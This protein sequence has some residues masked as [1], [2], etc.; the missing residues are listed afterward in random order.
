MVP[1]KRVQ[2]RLARLIERRRRAAQ[3]QPEAGDTLVEILISLAVIGITVT[4]ILGAFVTTISAST[5]QRN[6]ASADAFLRGF[7]N[8]AIYDI[9]LSSTP[10]FVACASSLPATYSQITPVAPSSTFSASIKTISAPP[11]G[12]SSSSPSTQ[13]LMAQVT[14]TNGVSDSTTF[15]V[16]PPSGTV[17]A[18]ATSVTS[19]S[20]STGP[21]A[22]GTSVVISGSGFTGVTSVKFG[23][24]AAT[25]YTRNNASSITATSPAGTGVVDVI[26]TTTAGSS[27]T[28][29]LDQ[30]TYA[31]TV[32]AISPSTGSTSGGTPVTITGTGLIGAS[33]VMFGTNAATSYNVNGASQITATSP[34]GSV[35]TVDITVT[36]IAGTSTTS[37]ADKFT[38]ATIV[39]SVSPNSGPALGGTVV[40]VNGSG[41]TGA[42]SVK[43]GSA[44]ATAVTVNSDTSITATSPPGTGAV[45]VIVTTPLG[46]SSPSINDRFT[47]NPSTAVGLGIVLQTGTHKPVVA[48]ASGT[49]SKCSSPNSSTCI[50]TSSSTTTCDISGIW[51]G[52]SSSATFY[53]ETVDATGNPVS[54]SSSNALPLGI[55]NATPSTI[56]IPASNASTS[57]SV[58]TA[59]L[60][61]NNS[62]VTITVTGG[63]WTLTVV[64]SS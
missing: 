26:V 47:Y 10:L 31:P 4:A 1:S 16:Y 13:Q 21:A 33:S 36:T 49:G 39:S 43:F 19:V 62:S 37:A 23:T 59:T 61:N 20:P 11:A 18:I 60:S 32:T 12:C 15:V 44:A 14:S 57:P 22:G 17:P 40:S 24:V 29:P 52:S 34:A 48:C 51:Q 42:T 2:G 53:L 3:A 30:F 28:N 50:M 25:S 64:V 27:P 45:D 7:V 63:G 9:S 58:V 55:T 35:G 5:E 54:Y 56:S 8:T 38:Y 6:L 41:F 46:T